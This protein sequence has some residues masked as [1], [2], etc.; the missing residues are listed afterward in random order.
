MN[1]GYH[2]HHS[3]IVSDQTNVPR[4]WRNYQRIQRNYESFERKVEKCYDAQKRFAD[5]HRTKPP[6]FKVN[7]KV[8]LDSSLVIN[9]G[10]IKFNQESQGF[11]VIK[12]ISKSFIKINI[13]CNDIFL[14]LMIRV[15]IKK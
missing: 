6:E 8:W 9:N 4:S 11:K 15:F 3:L 1:Y 10:N 13:N 14:K 7:D 5:K 2:S 12:N